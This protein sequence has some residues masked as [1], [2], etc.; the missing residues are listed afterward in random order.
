[1]GVAE[2]ALTLRKKKDPWHRRSVTPDKRL[3]GRFGMKVR[4]C[5]VPI[6]PCPL[7]G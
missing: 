6:T 2:V 5:V 3:W 7:G 4:H 1:M